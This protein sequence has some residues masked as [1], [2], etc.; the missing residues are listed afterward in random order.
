MGWGVGWGG[1]GGVEWGGVGWNGVGGVGRG[2][3]GGRCYVYACGG[4]G[5]WHAKCGVC[6]ACISTMLVVAPRKHTITKKRKA[7]IT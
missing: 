6:T 1:L 5:G 2:G 3:G 4:R 7:A